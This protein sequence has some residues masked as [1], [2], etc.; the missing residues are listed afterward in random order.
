M[1]PYPQIHRELVPN[2]SVICMYFLETYAHPVRLLLDKARG[3]E[4]MRLGFLLF[5]ILV[6]GIGML[7]TEH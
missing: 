3:W 2:R 6:G 7:W 1:W 5:D 4:K